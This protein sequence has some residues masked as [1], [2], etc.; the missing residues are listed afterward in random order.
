[1]RRFH[2]S[3]HVCRDIA[4][5]AGL[6]ALGEG[7]SANVFADFFVAELDPIKNRGKE[8]ALIMRGIILDV[9]HSAISPEEFPALFP[10]LQMMLYSSFNHTDQS[11]RY[12]ICIPTTHFVT[13]QINE[14]ICWTIAHKL[15]KLGYGDKGSERPHGLDTSKFEGTSMFYRPSHRP[16]MFLTENLTDRQPL[17]PYEWIDQAPPEAW[18]AA[19]MIE[20]A[21]QIV[22]PE[23]IASRAEDTPELG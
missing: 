1:M 18:L 6:G 3:R 5:L 16:G 4:P 11:P 2:A 14:V 9:E 23:E 17:N 22:P 7:E 20:E 21:P 8:N 10:E 19:K 15:S 12:R 13:P